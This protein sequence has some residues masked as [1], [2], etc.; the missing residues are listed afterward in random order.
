MQEPKAKAA[1]V[2]FGEPKGNAKARNADGGGGKRA[3]EG[4][5]GIQE[6][7]RIAKEAKRELEGIEEDQEEVLQRGRG[8]RRGG[9]VRERRRRFEGGKQMQA[10]ISKKIELIEE[11]ELSES[12]PED[13]LSSSQFA[14]FV[15]ASNSKGTQKGT[16]NVG[17]PIPGTPSSMEGFPPSLRGGGGGM[18]HRR[19]G[20]GG[21]RSISSGRV[22]VAQAYD[23]VSASMRGKIH[24]DVAT[25]VERLQSVETQT[26]DTRSAST[27]IEKGELDSL[28]T[29]K[30]SPNKKHV[31]VI[32]SIFEP[33]PDD[34]YDT[35]GVLLHDPLVLA[36]RRSKSPVPTS[37]RYPPPRTPVTPRNRTPPPPPP[38]RSKETVTPTPPAQVTT[39][40]VIAGMERPI[41]EEIYARDRDD[42]SPKQ[43]V[44][45]TDHFD[46]LL[47]TIEAEEEEAKKRRLQR[48]IDAAKAADREIKKLGIDFDNRL[49]PEYR[50]APANANASSVKR[51][52]NA[53]ATA[54]PAAANPAGSASRG[55]QPRRTLLLPRVILKTK[56]GPRTM[57]PE[58]N[59]VTLHYSFWSITVLLWAL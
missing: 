11:S 3:K 33:F 7:L 51:T 53:P 27:G 28:A 52:P 46:T 2:P 44:S 17:T 48:K 37:R 39:R 58:T 26:A 47:A 38:A 34:W 49:A 31:K 25:M 9:I 18:G 55:K 13:R 59:P 23:A 1:L 15:A 36:G 5:E 30:S 35:A 43:Q 40:R 14:A 50:L 12:G 19:G 10:E 54:A 6:N 29:E 45:V 22:K 20:R 41:T 24:K 21:G 32:R 42:D 16:P 8:P 57:Y 56:E 4:L